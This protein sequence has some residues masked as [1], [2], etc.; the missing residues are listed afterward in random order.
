[1]TRDSKD[2][3]VETVVAQCGVLKGITGS[4]G[5]RNG[6]EGGREVDKGC[7]NMARRWRSNEAGRG[8]LG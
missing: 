4:L 2:G 5:S 3:G 8:R 6:D 1:V 7:G